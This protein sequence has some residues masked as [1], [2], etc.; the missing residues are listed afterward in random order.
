MAR[1]ARAT[2]V[3]KSFDMKSASAA[4]ETEEK[5]RLKQL[6]QRIE[7][8]IAANPALNKYKDQLLLDITS[9]GL[10]IQIVD[11]QNRPMFALA[12]ATCSPI[13]RRSCTPSAMC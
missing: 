2:A 7:Q 9:E 5:E 1:R 8:T 10:R 11:E 3:K 4:V 12:N 6:K 13:P